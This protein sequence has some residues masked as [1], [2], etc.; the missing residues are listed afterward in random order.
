MN[1]RICK[2][3]QLKPTFARVNVSLK[4]V[5]FKLRQKIATP[6]MEAEI[7]NKHLEKQKLRKESKKIQTT[8]KKGLNSI[9]L[10]TVFHQLNVASKSKFKVVP[11]RH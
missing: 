1:E 11:I 7:Q 5:S 6:I 8:L 10:N 4:D 3:E 9:I 2:K